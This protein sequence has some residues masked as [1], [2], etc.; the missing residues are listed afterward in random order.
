MR[1]STPHRTLCALA[2]ALLTA[3]STAPRPPSAALLPPTPPTGDP[4]A[5]E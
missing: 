2:L 1:P 5:A 4:A 3:C